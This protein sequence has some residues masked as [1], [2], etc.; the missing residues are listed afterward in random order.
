MRSN[1]GWTVSISLPEPATG[2]SYRLGD[3]GAFKPTGLLDLLDQRTGQR[4]PNPSFEMPAK[5]AATVIQVR[6]ETADGGSVGPFPISPEN[7]AY[8]LGSGPIC[9]PRKETSMETPA[10]KI[11]RSFHEAYEDLA[12]SHGYKTRE[13]SA[14]PWEQVPEQ[15]KS[16][17]IAVAGKL[18]DDGVIFDA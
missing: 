16:L 12:P 13:A 15:N 18:L 6:Y 14:V 5:A 3:A 1:G 11:A 10:E 17:M 7:T 2:I 9:Y 4:M 8:A